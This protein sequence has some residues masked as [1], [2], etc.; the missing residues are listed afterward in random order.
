LPKFLDQSHCGLVEKFDLLRK[1][2]SGSRTLPSRDSGMGAKERPHS[3]RTLEAFSLSVITT[4]LS[5]RN[6]T[7]SS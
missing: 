4:Q 5:N 3:E 2:F 7:F 1:I 6:K